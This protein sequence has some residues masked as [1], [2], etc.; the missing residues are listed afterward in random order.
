MTKIIDA[1][2]LQ[3]HSAT[4]NDFETGTWTVTPHKRIGMSDAAIV[5]F[6]PMTYDT[7]DA[8]GGGW[9]IHPLPF[10][11]KGGPAPKMLVAV[12]DSTT[13][14]AIGRLASSSQD[15]VAAYDDGLFKNVNQARA[16]YPDHFVESICVKFGDR[17]DWADTEPGNMTSAEAVTSFENGLVRGIYADKERWNTELI[18]MLRG[19]QKQPLRWVADWTG[20]PHLV[21]LDDGVECDACQWTNHAPGK[22]NVD[23]SLFKVSALS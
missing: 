18:H 16:L 17:A 15:A 1:A 7:D 19:K 12:Y 23:E 2:L 3:F 6:E 9:S 22:H 10:I 5:S 8:T 20:H 4:P 14:G 11:V 13:I 21:T